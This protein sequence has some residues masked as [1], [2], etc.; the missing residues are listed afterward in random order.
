MKDLGNVATSQPGGNS[1]V[2]ITPIDAWN[3]CHALNSETSYLTKLIDANRDGTYALISNPEW[4]AIARNIE[5]E[6]SNWNGST[7]NRGWS[8]NTAY[9]DSYSHNQEPNSTDAACLFSSGANSCAPSGVYQYK[10]THELSNGNTIWDFSGNL[11]EWTDWSKEDGTFTLAPKDCS[12]YW[13]EFGH[14]N[15]SSF[16]ASDYMPLNSSL[17]SS[18]NNVGLFH[19][20]PGG[21]AARGGDWT[22]GERAGIYSLY[23]YDDISYSY[24]RAGFRCVFRPYQE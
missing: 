4:M 2:N 8:A 20:G 18:A 6:S 12:D 10:R 7:L 16:A 23:S 13:V 14:V 3:A 22:Y 11:V 5:D 17:T 9:G 24:D 21:A 1:W 15:C 19:A